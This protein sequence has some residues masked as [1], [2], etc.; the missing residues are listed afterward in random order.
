MISLQV[1]IPDEPDYS[2]ATIDF[3]IGR[4]KRDHSIV[5]NHIRDS[6]AHNLQALAV[7]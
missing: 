2:E 7:K 3:S 1:S 6:F 4:S 5:A